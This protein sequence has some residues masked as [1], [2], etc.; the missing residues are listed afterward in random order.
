[1]LGFTTWHP[2]LVVTPLMSYVTDVAHLLFAYGLFEDG[3]MLPYHCFW[4]GRSSCK[5]QFLLEN[6]VF[7]A[8]FTTIIEDVELAYRLRDAGLAVLYDR[9][10]VTHM[11]RPITYDEFCERCERRGRALARFVQLHPEAET[12]ELGDTRDAAIR[13]QDASAQLSQQVDEVRELETGMKAGLLSFDENQDRLHELYAATFKAFELKGI[14]DARG[15]ADGSGVFTQ[16]GRRLAAC[17]PSVVPVCHFKCPTWI[18]R[19][20]SR[21]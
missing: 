20:P 9:N 4:G 13:W 8:A 6:G 2:K 3:Q 11:A 19:E 12:K 21:V 15:G 10:A 5:R 7:N 16:V 1:M 18:R 14:A 17:P